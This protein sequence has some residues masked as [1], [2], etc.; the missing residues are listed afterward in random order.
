MRFLRRK[1][2]KTIEVRLP[3]SDKDGT[4]DINSGTWK[5]IVRWAEKELNA[6]RAKNDYLKVTWEQ[7]N[8]LRGRIKALKDLLGLPDDRSTS[9]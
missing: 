1:G 2:N 4:L 5:Y 8:A 9:H 7:T 3:D 6:A